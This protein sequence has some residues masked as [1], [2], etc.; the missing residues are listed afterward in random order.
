MNRRTIL[1]DMNTIITTYCEGC[2]V[3]SALRKEY[4]KGYA[5]QFCIRECTV[6]EQIKKYGEALLNHKNGQT[7][8]EHMN[9]NQKG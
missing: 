7:A 6:G 8:E 9:Q 1:E 5:H 4:N 3:K 2:F